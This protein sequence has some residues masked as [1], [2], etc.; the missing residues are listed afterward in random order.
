MYVDAALVSKFFSQFVR[1]HPYWFS[2]GKII[3]KVVLS[4]E[5]GKSERKDV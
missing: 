1:L 2:F 5:M 4:R 3:K